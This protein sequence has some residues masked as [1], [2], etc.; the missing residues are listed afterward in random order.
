MWVLTRVHT[1][2]Y[3][4]RR[5]EMEPYSNVVFVQ[6]QLE[7]EFVA[8]TLHNYFMSQVRD[9]Q[10]NSCTLSNSQNYNY[11]LHLCAKAWQ[12]CSTETLQIHVFLQQCGSLLATWIPWIPI[13]FGAVYLTFC[14]V[15]GENLSGTIK[16]HLDSFSLKNLNIS[17]PFTRT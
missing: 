1:D 12:R 7:M 5:A 6:V 10:A 14:Y 15:L 11:L 9:E 2:C 3:W 17:G 4:C 16:F 8:A 13:M